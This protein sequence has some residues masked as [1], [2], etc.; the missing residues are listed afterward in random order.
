MSSSIAKTIPQSPVNISTNNTPT[1]NLDAVLE[2]NY[3]SSPIEILNNGDL[4]KY[5][6]AMLK[7]ITS[8]VL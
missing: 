4:I 3:Q 5:Y 8:V 1:Q 6:P 2:T 7:F